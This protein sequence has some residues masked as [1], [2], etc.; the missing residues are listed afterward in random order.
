MNAAELKEVYLADERSADYAFQR[1]AHCLE[2]YGET[3]GFTR[4]AKDNL[5][6][7]NKRA[8]RSFQLYQKAK[9]HDHS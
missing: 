4:A 9:T 8:E 7:A 2:K 6:V 3:H 5:F 1:Y